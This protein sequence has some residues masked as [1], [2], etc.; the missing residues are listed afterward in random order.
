MDTHIAGRAYYVT[1]VSRGI[2][3]AIA[4]S[5]LE[6]GAMVAGCA[7]DV[8]GLQE[9]HRSLPRVVLE[10]LVLSVTDVQD[11]SR[12]ASALEDAVTRFG[13]LDGVVANAGAG[14]PGGVLDTPPTG[15]EE[16][17]KVKIGSVLN[18]VKPALPALRESDAARIVV[19]G[20]VTA[21][22]P[23]PT[24]AAVSAARAAVANMTRSLAVELAPEKILVN[25]VNLGAI[26]TD[27][28][29]EHYQR[30]GE[31]VSYEEWA[32]AET[33]RRGILLG[34]M[35]TPAEVAPM[36]MMLLSPLSSYVTGT[37][38]DVAGGMA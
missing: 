3:R 22:T 25:A 8:L 37:S 36:V 5:L 23:E 28:Q 19:M 20:G 21:R 1:G 24:M 38:I 14:I 30:S 12:M 13:R 29:R 33:V 10:R 4:Q 31:S 18:L 7:R 9:F 17:V 2:G 32:D 15:W 27:R 35:G 11:E 26:S 16:Q 34:R 6:E